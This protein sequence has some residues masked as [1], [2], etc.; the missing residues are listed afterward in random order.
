[1]VAKLKKD[2]LQEAMALEAA[3]SVLA[4]HI[5]CRLA[6]AGC[7]LRRGSEE[8]HAKNLT[9]RWKH[10]ASV[11]AF[12]ILARAPDFTPIRKLA[13]DTGTTPEKMSAWWRRLSKSTLP[14]YRI[15]TDEPREIELFRHGSEKFH[16]GNGVKLQLDTSM[17][18]YAAANWV[19]ESTFPATLS[20][21]KNYHGA[22]WRQAT[23][24]DET[25]SEEEKT[26]AVR[27]MKDEM[28]K[29]DVAPSKQA[30]LFNKE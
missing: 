26:R 7:R 1:M 14:V 3:T 21:Q 11:M 2:E 27:R 15:G 4:H 30:D 9:R 5:K 18:T 28:Q 16:A 25:K 13:A 24:A 23:D 19:T 29:P 17:L 12:F 22:A 8:G 10:F 6:Q 20:K